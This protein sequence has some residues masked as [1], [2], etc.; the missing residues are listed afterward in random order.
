MAIK[1]TIKERC[2]RCG[3]INA[4]LMPD[5]SVKVGHVCKNPTQGPQAPPYTFRPKEVIFEPA[6]PTQGA[7]A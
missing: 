6:A 7:Q 5:G 3:E 4:R 2:D 1:R